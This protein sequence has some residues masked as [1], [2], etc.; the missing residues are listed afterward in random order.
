MPLNAICRDVRDFLSG[1]VHD[2]PEVFPAPRVYYRRA[3]TRLARRPSAEEAAARKGARE[4]IGARVRHWAAL[5]NLDYRR[6]SIKDQRTLWGS[7]SGRKNLNFNWRL[8]AA[9]PEV[10][11]YVVIHE[12]CHLREMNHSRNFWALVNAHCP[13]YAAR[14]RWLRDNCSALRDRALY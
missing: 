8:A 5:M 1:L 10:L 3:P 12:L 2:L 14:R 11:D 13:A 9:P 6:V 4:I 7:C